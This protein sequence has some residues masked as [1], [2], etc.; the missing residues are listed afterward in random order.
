MSKPK[1]NVERVRSELSESAFFRRPQVEQPEPEP[2]A[3]PAT[4]VI[5]DQ[6][7]QELDSLAAEPTTNVQVFKR[8]NVQT[9]PRTLVRASFDI[10]QDQQQ[11]LA[12]IQATRFS[13]T[14]KK[15][16]MGELAQEALDLYIRAM[17]E[18]M[19]E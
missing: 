8:S 9:N 11:A 10:F 6:P 7:S 1:L 18:Q 17:K 3:E 5:E 19:E 13:R 2:L 12:R 14:G 15:P 16:K 4:S